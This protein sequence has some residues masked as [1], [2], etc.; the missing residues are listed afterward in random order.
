MNWG[1][2]RFL[3]G[4]SG[5]PL[6]ENTGFPVTFLYFRASSPH[7]QEQP[8][9]LGQAQRSCALGA[10]PLRPPLGPTLL[11]PGRTEAALCG[12]GPPIPV[13]PEEPAPSTHLLGVVTF[14]FRNFQRF[15]R[16]PARGLWSQMG[17][18]EGAHSAKL[19]DGLWA[20]HG[21]GQR[22]RDPPGPTPPPI[23]FAGCFY[24]NR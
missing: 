11:G 13:G 1:Q 21:Q 17:G 9:G 19:T 15:A 12:R 22:E 14:D 3:E 24:Q 10:G 6:R 18:S 20:E 5:C 8:T 7:N 4:D 2:G 23:L 16:A